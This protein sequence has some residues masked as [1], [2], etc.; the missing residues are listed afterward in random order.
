MSLNS[1][2]KKIDQIDAKVIKLL[3]E[4]AELSQSIGNKKLKSNTGIY[5]PHREKQV[6]DNIKKLN[7]GPMSKEAFEAIY[8][9][10]MSSSLALEKSLQIAHLGIDGSYTHLAANKK[11]GSQVGYV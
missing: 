2:R 6:F 11:F 4:R 8:R 3:N 9:E 10:I 7:E 5:A 1:F